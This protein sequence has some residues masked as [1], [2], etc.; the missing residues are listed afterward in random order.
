MT[1]FFERRKGGEGGTRP[2]LHQ[3]LVA[4]SSVVEAGTR[5]RFRLYDMIMI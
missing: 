5:E 1:L 2:V 3:G 4:L